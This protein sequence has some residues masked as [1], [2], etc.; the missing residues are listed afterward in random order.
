MGGV[1]K[2]LRNTQAVYLVHITQYLTF[3]RRLRR[4]SSTGRQACGS[5]YG[6]DVSRPGGPSRSPRPHLPARCKGWLE[7]PSWIIPHPHRPQVTNPHNA[8]CYRGA[9]ILFQQ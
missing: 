1:A 7:S 5:T 6:K 2:S 9:V 4:E 3:R 8:R